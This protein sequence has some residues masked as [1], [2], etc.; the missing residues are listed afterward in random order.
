MPR[1]RP[2][3]PADITQPGWRH[4]LGRT[5]RV[6]SSQ[7]SS[8]I[9]AGIAFYGVWSFFPAVAALVALAGLLFGP[10]DVLR[11]LSSV[12]SDLPESVSVIVVGQL[13][14]IAS[15]SRTLSS[16]TLIGALVFALWSGMRAMRGLIGALNLIYEEE[17]KRAFWHLQLLALLFTCFGGV[18]LLIVFGTILAFPL[19]AQG[20]FL[21]DVLAAARW[22]VLVAAVML[23]LA[24]LYRYAPSRRKARWRWVSWGA[25]ASAV[26]W[27]VVTLLFSYYFAHFAGFN[28]LIGSLGAVVIFFFWSYV[29]VLTILLGAQVNAEIERETEAAGQAKAV[30]EVTVPAMD[31]PHPSRRSGRRASRGARSG[32]KR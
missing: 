18:F 26:I 24:T 5:W 3:A 16:L 14:R 29:T 25:T 20:S 22:P 15:H 19:R 10:D 21:S 31:T 11:L 7:H 30:R 4:L 2:Q 12:R 28:P 23:S 9:G 13:A 8:L 27:A 1:R 6:A 32:R 17:E